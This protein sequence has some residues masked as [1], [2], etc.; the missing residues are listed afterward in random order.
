MKAAPGFVP[1]VPQ[2]VEWDPVAFRKEILNASTQTFR[3]WLKARV[4][5]L[6]RERISRDRISVLYVGNRTEVC[7]DRKVRFEFKMQVRMEGT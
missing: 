2:W 4:E 1:P 3:D 6:H 5:Q 7:V